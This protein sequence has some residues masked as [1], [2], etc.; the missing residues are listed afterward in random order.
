MS[1]FSVS[2]GGALTPVAGS[3]FPTGDTPESVAFSPSGGLLATADFYGNTVSVFSV[4]G[5]G[6]LS[7]VPGSP[8]TTGTQ[9]GLGGV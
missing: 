9:P 6:A 5:A 1:V 3:P 8:F 7:P 4:S 2:A